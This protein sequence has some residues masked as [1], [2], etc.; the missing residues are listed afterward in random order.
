MQGIMD[1]INW[2][3]LKAGTYQCFPS[4]ASRMPKTPQYNADSRVLHPHRPITS[5]C[6][7]LLITAHDIQLKLL[8]DPNMSHLPLIEPS[9]PIPVHTAIELCMAVELTIW[10]RFVIDVVF[11]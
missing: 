10:Q 1:I 7:I 11:C 8:S 3:G 9:V 2:H 4:H 6:L 5:A